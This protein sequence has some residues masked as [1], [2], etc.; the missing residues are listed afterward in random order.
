M[1]LRATKAER[2]IKTT[3][4]FCHTR[5]LKFQSPPGQFSQSSVFFHPA[6]CWAISFITVKIIPAN[7]IVSNAGGEAS[8]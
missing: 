5:Y 6:F 4:F 8:L 3:R 1:S 2:D 7:A